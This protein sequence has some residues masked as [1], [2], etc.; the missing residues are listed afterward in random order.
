MLIIKCLNQWS[1][2]ME[3]GGY[4]YVFMSGKR[5]SLFWVLVRHRTRKKIK[6][7]RSDVKLT[8]FCFDF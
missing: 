6:I 4:R 7:N 5:F 8:R 1:A 2:G 3:T